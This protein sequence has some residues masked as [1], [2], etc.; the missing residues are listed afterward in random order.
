MTSVSLPVYDKKP[1]Q[2]ITEKVQ[3]NEAIWITVTRE[4]RVANLL[5][6]AGTDVPIEYI[7]RLMLPYRLGVNGYAFIVTNNGYILTHPD[8]RPVFEGILKPAYNR[9][10]VI[11]IEIP[12]DETEPRN[13]SDAI[14][15]FRRKIVFH[16]RG[17]ATFRIKSHLDDMKRIL[18]Q[19]RHFFFM[20]I[21]GTPF[22]LVIALPHK[23]GFNRIQ[24]PVESDI[25]RMRSNDKIK[26]SLAQFFTGNWTIHPDWQY[27]RYLDDKESFNTPEEEFLHF[28]K[29]MEGPGWKWSK[30]CDRK[31]ICKVVADAKIT[32]WFN[33]NIT[34][35]TKEE[36]GA[37]LVKKI[38]IVVA[39]MA[40]H[41]GLTRWQDFPQNI[42][43]SEHEPNFQLL[44]NKAIDEIWYRRAVEH[45][46]VDSSNFV[47]AVP[48]DVGNSSHT[49]VTVS[50]AI[51][52]EDGTKKAPAAV[53]GYQFYHKA[54]YQLFTKITSSCG[55]MPCK[56][57]CE[58]EELHCVILDDNGYVIIS[59][60][61]QETGYFFGKVRSDVMH[62]LVEEGIY[63][64]TTMF[65]Y[66][67]L[68]PEPIDTASPAT[69]ILSPSVHLMKLVNW[70]IGTIV[71][72]AKSVFPH[73]LEVLPETEHLGNHFGSHE[74]YNAELHDHTET[75]EVA[76]GEKEFIEKF[77]ITKTKPE[78]CDHQMY[79]Y[80]LVHYS[81]RNISNSGYNR[82][83][84]D[85]TRPYIVQKVTGS[86]LILVVVNNLCREN[87]TRVADSPDPVQVDYNMSLACYRAFYND[88]PRRH[89]MTCINRHI[90]E[91]EIKLCGKATNISPSRIFQIMILTL[92][93]YAVLI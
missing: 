42:N 38:G 8:L 23:Y 67:G 64:V 17:N 49:L 52:K 39:F 14:K 85:C 66:Q 90:N 63:R 93:S 59:D 91:S 56:R 10:D 86:N 33:Q 46:Y 1:R 28:L 88:F 37:E 11:E 24:H 58:S 55:D 30:E 89:Y 62:Q 65:D 9:V 80:S 57:T 4:E 73:Y 71:F 74:D 77:A 5:G 48:H 12:D 70:A 40:T 19:T 53:V 69:K 18:V 31:L 79:M 45:H 61:L 36:N 76:Y 35:T 75:E 20:G 47:Y 27:C 87:S 26:G 84:V 78:P 6:V 72:F 92:I 83:M 22:S 21:N 60:N 3:I 68:C 32:S 44:H 82:S 41:S 34:T 29:K 7:Q 50:H 43:T 15:E 25:H 2:N 16:N 13:F 81:E 54:L 51:F